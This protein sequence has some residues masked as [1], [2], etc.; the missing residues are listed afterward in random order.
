MRTAD[1]LRPVPAIAEVGPDDR[2]PGGV[3]WLLV[4]ILS[5]YRRFV[6]PL[7]LPRC[8][9]VPSCSVYAMEAIARH[10]A[11]KGGALAVRRL[12]R[13]HPFHPGGHDPVPP[14]VGRRSAPAPA[15]PPVEPPSGAVQC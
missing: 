14:K 1:P 10:G 3:A 4:A 7:L 8:R 9:F 12:V 5:G 13:C 11:R 6:S 2:D 15:G